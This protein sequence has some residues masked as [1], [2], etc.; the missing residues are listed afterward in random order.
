MNIA[1]SRD[2]DAVFGT[3]RFLAPTGAVVWRSAAR[4]PAASRPT[5][6]GLPVIESG[7]LLALSVLLMAATMWIV[8]RHA[9]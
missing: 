2:E 8:R 6:S 9:T 7:R 1:W 3:H 4:G 5:G